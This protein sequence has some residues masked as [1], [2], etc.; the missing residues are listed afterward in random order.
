MTIT[1]KIIDQFATEHDTSYLLDRK[2]NL[3]HVLYAEHNPLTG[4]K[5]LMTAEEENRKLPRFWV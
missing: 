1:A 5:K 2:V 3:S 4:P